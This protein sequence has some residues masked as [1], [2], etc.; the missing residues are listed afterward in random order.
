MNFKAPRSVPLALLVLA[1]G[2]AALASAC[3]GCKNAKPPPNAASDADAAQIDYGPPTARLY[4]ISNM[5]GAL[6]PC[7]CTKDQLGGLDHVGAWIAAQR[8]KVPASAVAAAGPL[9]FMDAK[10]KADHAEQDTEKADAIAGALQTLGLAA[11]APSQN[12]WAAGGDKLAVIAK[13]SGAAMLVANASYD[14]APWTGTALK[15]INGV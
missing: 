2:A 8:A 14:G 12:E 11:F 15:E 13:D 1:I 3:G 5:A 4:L 6:E 9:F 10:L 7:G